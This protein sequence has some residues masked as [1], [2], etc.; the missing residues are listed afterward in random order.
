M[1][2]APALLRFRGVGLCRTLL[3]AALGSRAFYRHGSGSHDASIAPRT[4]A[5]MVAATEG[6]DRLSKWFHSRV[7]NPAPVI[8]YLGKTGLQTPAERQ[9][10]WLPFS[11]TK[12]ICHSSPR[13]KAIR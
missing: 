13:S 4:R 8:W 7:A 10:G 11:M 6:P 1:G 9:A 3:R 2:M 12:P 5:H